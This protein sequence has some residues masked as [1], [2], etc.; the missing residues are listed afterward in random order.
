MF[1]TFCL[2]LTF[3]RSE[4][5]KCTKRIKTCS[6]GSCCKC[7]IVIGK[8]QL[9]RTF[10][11]CGDIFLGNESYLGV[12]LHYTTLQWHTTR[13]WRNLQFKVF[14]LHDLQSLNLRLGV[15]VLRFKC[16][17]FYLFIYYL[18]LQYKYITCGIFPSISCWSS[19]VQ[20]YPNFVF[21]STTLGER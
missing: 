4:E 11:G 20:C 10:L 13:A 17:L 19:L 7:V 6:T 2:C 14:V 8:S 15:K 16:K 5:R 1:M 18:D 9:I 3:N 21:T 12:T